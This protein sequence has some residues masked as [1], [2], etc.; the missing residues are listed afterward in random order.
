MSHLGVDLS[1]YQG[2]ITPQE[3][4][5]LK[6]ANVEFVYC[7]ATQGTDYIN[8]DAAQQVRV[9][10]AAGFHVGLYHYLDVAKSIG[11]EAQYFVAAAAALGGSDLPLA[12]DIEEPDPAGWADLATKVVA[13]AMQIENEPLVIRSPLS[14]LYVNLNFASNLAGFP[15]G[16]LVWLADPNPGAPHRSC[17]ILQGAPR[18]EGGFSSID[19][20]VFLGTEAQWSAFVTPGQAPAPSP[21]PSP[22][23]TPQPAPVPVPPVPQPQEF[24]MST[25]PNLTAGAKSDTV[26][27]AQALLH[28]KFNQVG[29]AVD[30]D[31][32]P[33]TVAAV[34]AVQHYFKLT[35]DG[36]VGPHTWAVLL[37]A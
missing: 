34:E 32:G 23:P 26:K 36:V 4:A 28:A 22:A 7:K 24:D 5:A 14:I 33:V 25:L 9:L 10:R 21:T 8:P 20:D 19:P 17:L 29:V 30:G 13:F 15:W 6:A 31:Y 35:V 1:S 11:E 16:R 3:V 12:I 37:D 2:E 27:S 18:A